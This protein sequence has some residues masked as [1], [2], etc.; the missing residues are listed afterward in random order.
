MVTATGLSGVSPPVLAPLPL[1]STMA[2]PMPDAAAPTTRLMAP[3]LPP[4]A[5]PE[6]MDRDPVLPAAEPPELRRMLPDTPTEPTL[7]DWRVMEP[8]EELTLEPDW[9]RKDPPMPVN[10]L[11]AD[12]VTLPPTAA[13]TVDSEEPPL[14]NTEPAEVPDLVVPT[15]MLMEPPFPDEA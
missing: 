6:M 10:A 5:A 8:D 15:E 9:I 2:P 13:A 14:M 12:N 1:D 4:V 3:P 11:P 7:R